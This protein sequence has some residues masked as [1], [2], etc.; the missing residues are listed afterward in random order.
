MKR[1]ERGKKEN[2]E[3]DDEAK[4]DPGNVNTETV[5]QELAFNKIH[6]PFNSLDLGN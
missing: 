5:H 3:R 4:L 6:P 2:N 1:R